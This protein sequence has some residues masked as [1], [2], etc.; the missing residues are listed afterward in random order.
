MMRPGNQTL[1]WLALAQELQALAIAVH[2]MHQAAGEAQRA[3]ALAETV[4]S[5]LGPVRDRLD[6]EHAAAVPTT[7]KLA[8]PSRLARV[9]QA[10]IS[11][12]TRRPAPPAAPAP[13]PAPPRRPRPAPQRKPGRGP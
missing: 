5:E 9:G 7:P 10:P 11:D 12:V 4:R 1:F 2:D 13:T 6:D 8:R 3:A